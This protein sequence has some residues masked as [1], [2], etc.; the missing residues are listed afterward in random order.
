MYCILH[1]IH[2]SK[3]LLLTDNSSGLDVVV[4]GWTASVVTVTTGAVVSGAP[5]PGVFDHQSH[6][7]V[8]GLKTNLL[9]QVCVTRYPLEHLKMKYLHVCFG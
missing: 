6:W 2:C 7:F 9:G 4:V 5:Q 1:T 8:T 3:H